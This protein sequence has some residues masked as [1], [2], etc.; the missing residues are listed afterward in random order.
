MS[1]QGHPA[2]SEGWRACELRATGPQLMPLT[3][4]RTQTH[5]HTHAWA[6][7]PLHTLIRVH[8]RGTYPHSHAASYACAHSF[9][10]SDS[11]THVCVCAHAREHMHRRAR[12]N[13]SSTAR[14]HHTST[15]QAHPPGHMNLPHTHVPLGTYVTQTHKPYSEGVDCLSHVHRAHVWT[16]RARPSPQTAADP[17]PPGAPMLSRL[18][19]QVLPSE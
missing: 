10:H 2:L 13:P 12:A 5:G 6:L 16:D 18:G 14:P 19:P 9:H 17:G 7:T 15:T 4:T 8:T 1:R 3:H 11:H